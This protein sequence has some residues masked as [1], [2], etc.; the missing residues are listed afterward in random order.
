MKRPELPS[1]HSGDNV[2]AGRGARREKALGAGARGGAR[3]VPAAREKP[4]RRRPTKPPGA[5][6]P[7][8]GACEGQEGFSPDH[9]PPRWQQGH[10]M[11]P[12]PHQQLRGNARRDGL[13]NRVLGGRGAAPAALPEPGRAASPRVLARR[14]QPQASLAEPVPVAHGAEPIW[15]LRAGAPRPR[16]EQR[17]RGTA[18]FGWREIPRLFRV[19]ILE[20][21]QGRQLRGATARGA[22][23]APESPAETRLRT[24]S[25]PRLVARSL[26]WDSGGRAAGSQVWE[27][28]RQ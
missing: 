11:R 5:T 24:R 12:G 15:H 19:S 18:R 17:G 16:G 26:C 28:Q 22:T 8:Q 27:E 13:R 4:P 7:A 2:G 21:V 10:R 23:A 1:H 6:A 9:R 14:K 20:A 3:A 25:P